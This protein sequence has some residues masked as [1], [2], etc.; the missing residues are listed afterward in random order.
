MDLRMQRWEGDELAPLPDDEID[1]GILGIVRTLH[2]AG[3]LCTN[4]G[5]CYRLF[6]QPR[7][8][9]GNHPEWSELKKADSRRLPTV[10]TSP[11]DTIVLEGPWA[12]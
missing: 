6:V 10:A 3:G 4:S 12:T 7:G 11:I 2:A 5:E 1:D 9:L 8:F